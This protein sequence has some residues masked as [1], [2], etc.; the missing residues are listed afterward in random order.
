[1]QEEYKRFFLAREPYRGNVVTEDW[2]NYR[3]HEIDKQFKEVRIFLAQTWNAKYDIAGRICACIKWNEEDGFIKGLYVDTS[4]RRQG[5][6]KQLVNAAM[7]WFKD[8]QCKRVQLEVLQENEEVQAFYR[9][10]WNFE[11]RWTVMTTDVS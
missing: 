5:V 6:G 9:K 4:Y 8:N 11:P 10:H 2:Y 7:D 1:M 3:H